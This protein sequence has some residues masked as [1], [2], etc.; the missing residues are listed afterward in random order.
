[1][2]EL[3]WI[4][5]GLVSGM[6]ESRDI[7]PINDAEG[8]QYIRYAGGNISRQNKLLLTSV[9]E[10]EKMIGRDLGYP[11][12][13]TYN[14]A[15]MEAINEIAAREGWRYISLEDAYSDPLCRKYFRLKKQINL[16]DKYLIDQEKLKKYNMTKASENDVL[17]V[18]I[19]IIALSAPFLIAGIVIP[20]GLMIFVTSL[21]MVTSVFLLESS[22]PTL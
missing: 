22:K 18:Q 9:P 19:A 17:N 12:Y 5:L 13:K 2:D 16:E 15:K 3:F 10:L 14:Q 11:R 7:K 1:M 6:G 4:G 20:S 8:L 21:I